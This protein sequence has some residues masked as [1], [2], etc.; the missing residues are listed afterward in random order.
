MTEE[1][2]QPI[3]QIQSVYLKDLSLEQ[4]NSPQI[5]LEKDA[6]AFDVAINVSYNELGN[7]FHEAAVTATVTAK[8]GEKVAYLVEGK[9]CGIFN[10]QGIPEEA[11]DSVLGINCPAIIYPYLRANI[12]DTITKAGFPPIHLAEINFEAHYRERMQ[13]QAAQAES[14]AVAQ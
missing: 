10:I 6:P 1:T 4:P 3:F 14:P 9:Q 11:M 2:K 13:Q 12:A 8:I 5:F 7:G